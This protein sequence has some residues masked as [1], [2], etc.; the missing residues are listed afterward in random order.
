MDKCG[1][2]VPEGL[3][4]LGAIA[5]DIIGSPVQQLRQRLGD[6]GLSRGVRLR[7]ARRGTRPRPPHAEVTH[8]HAEGIKGA[9]AVAAAV[10]LARTGHGKDRIRQYLAETFEYDLDRTL[11]DIRPRYAFDV[12]CQ[13]SVPEAIIAFLASTDFEDAVRKAISLGGDS[14]T[15]ACI[16]GGIAHAFYGGVPDPIADRVYAIL[17]GPLSAVTRRFLERFPT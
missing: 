6:A 15:Q 10:F 16:A 7:L 9:Q 14:D 11:E 13:G 8:N 2:A 1:T 17:D 5:G 3:P 4:M 12:T